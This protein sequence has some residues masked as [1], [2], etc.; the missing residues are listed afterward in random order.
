MKHEAKASVKDSGI[1]PAREE[2]VCFQ[3]GARAP[4]F[5]QIMS[6]SVGKVAS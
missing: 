5:A 3:M 2:K 1:E 6:F 4:T